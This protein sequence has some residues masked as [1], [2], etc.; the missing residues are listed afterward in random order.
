MYYLLSAIL[1]LS[2]S[3]CVENSTTKPLTPTEVQ[4]IAQVVAKRLIAPKLTDFGTRTAVIDGL[5]SAQRAL[6]STSPRDLMDQIPE[7]LGPENKDISDL[8]KVLIAE[9]VDL[10]QVPEIQGKAYIWAVLEG[11][12]GGLE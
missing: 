7:F 11:I 6:Q 2:L 3:G 12:Q 5:E 1:L 9:R 4:V 8:I 10:T